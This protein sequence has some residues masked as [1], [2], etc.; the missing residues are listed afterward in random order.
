MLP[1]V[2][3]D[4]HVATNGSVDGPAGTERSADQRVSARTGRIARLEETQCKMLLGHGGN[5][6][7]QAIGPVIDDDQPECAARHLQKRGAVVVGVIPV[8]AAH[9][10]C[11]N[12]VNVIALVAAFEITGD[13]VTGRFARNV[14][15]VGV[16]IRDIRVLEHIVL[17]DL[18]LERQRVFET[19]HVRLA[20]RHGDRWSR[21]RIGPA[22]LPVGARRQRFA[23]DC[24]A[25][26]AHFEHA[27]EVIAHVCPHEWLWIAD[28]IRTANLCM[29]RGDQK[30]HDRDRQE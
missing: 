5:V 26:L 6:C 28:A 8:R 23:V 4:T 21:N 19:Q 13:I 10:V 22:F 2:G 14:Q 9:V 3:R 29:G 27:V 18:R 16:H 20:G 24:E 25:G 11:G 30:W 17:H 7:G 12:I 15:A 1:G